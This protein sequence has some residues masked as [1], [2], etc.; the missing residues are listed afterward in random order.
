MK[1]GSVKIWAW[2]ASVIFHLIILTVLAISRFSLSSV[3]GEQKTIPQAKISSVKRL[4]DAGGV[5][6]KPKVKM[7]CNNSGKRQLQTPILKNTVP[8]DES[9]I[10]TGSDIFSGWVGSEGGYDEMSMDSQP[11]VEFFGSWTN[12]RKVCY[13]VDCSGSMQG[14]FGSVK[15]NLK[16]SIGKLDADQYFYIIFF[17]NNRLAEFGEGR[18]VRA[19]ARSKTQAC[20]FV[21]RIRPAGETNAIEALERAVQI[22]DN[23]GK[24]PAIIYFLTDGFELSDEQTWFFCDKTEKLLKKFAP[25]TKINTIGFWPQ[26][27]DRKMLEMT[28]GL[29]GGEFICITDNQ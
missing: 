15:N 16:K 13:L 8:G 14:V 1:Q 11:G 21:D 29:S 19:S 25:L 9:L 7:P 23:F 27:N 5:I 26:S 22:R 17:G 10:S 3:H 24:A 2:T 28:A 12:E 6:S 20:D 18:L 4:I